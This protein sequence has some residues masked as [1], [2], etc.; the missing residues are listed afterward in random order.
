MYSRLSSY[1]NMFLKKQQQPIPA[2][3]LE[4]L[5]KYTVERFFL[6]KVW[7]Q[8]V[9]ANM[10]ILLYFLL[11]SLLCFTLLFTLY[12]ALLYFVLF[13]LLCFALLFTLYFTLLYFYFTLLYF[14][15][16]LSL[17]NILLTSQNFSPSHSLFSLKKNSFLLLPLDFQIQTCIKFSTDCKIGKAFKRCFT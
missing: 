11:F 13:A 14:F 9:L 10:F 6:R 4:K 1:Q 16:T 3:F 12:F 15:F 17:P 7:S 5:S 8:S 2:V